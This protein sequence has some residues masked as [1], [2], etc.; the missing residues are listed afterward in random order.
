[1]MLSSSVA[2]QQLPVLRSIIETQV[3]S[4]LPAALD[5]S[6]V[7]IIGT[8]DGSFHC[9]EALAISMLKCLPEY[10]SALVIR[11]RDAALLAQCSI[12]VDVGA[13]YNEAEN[14]FDHHQREFQ[15]TLD[16]YKTRLSSA[17]LVYKHFGK[18]IL[19]QV[20]EWNASAV[21]DAFIDIC[22]D[23]VYKN[24]IEH[25]DAID[26]GISVADGELR[27]RI[28][29]TL[30]NRVGT[31][32]PA[33]N[34]PQSAETFNARF[35]G[36]MQLTV[37][38]FCDSAIG[39][40]KYWWPARNIVQAAVDNRFSAHPSG[41]IIVLEQFC[42]WKEHLFEIEETVGTSHN[43]IKINIILYNFNYV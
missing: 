10:E 15:G 29:S 17:G 20:L 5:K 7:K 34:E 6:L 22:Y 39:L 24:F 23:K 11:T 28:S 27:Y 14:R 33:W 19:R 3:L 43:Y 38:E 4:A 8:H 26:N 30:S 41:K 31:L 16:N 9:D 35:V 32:N 36:A 25:I 40:W 42:P 13:V 18:R 1:M 2:Q 12:V 37:S 21:P